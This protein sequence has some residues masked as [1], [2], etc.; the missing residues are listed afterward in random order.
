MSQLLKLLDIKYPIIQAG[1]AGGITTPGLVAATAEAGGLGTIG[2]G[3][4]D[5]AALRN[6]II[7]TRDLTDRPFAVNLFA[8][9]LNASS[10]NVQEMQKF[11]NKYRKEL[12]LQLGSYT[13]K[14]Y[15]YLEEKVSVILEEKISIVSTAFGVL[16]AKIIGQ[17]KSGKVVL[18]GM[19]TSL[20]EA[21]QLEEAG[22]DVIVAQGSEAGGHRGTFD[23]KKYPDGCNIGLHV[24]VEELL[25]NTRLPI[26]A[27]GGIYSKKQAD[28]LM[29][30]GASGVQIGTRF[31]LAREAGTN[32]AYREALLRARGEDTKL[33]KVFSGRPARAIRNRFIDEVDASRLETLPFPVQNQMTK[34]IR[35]A[36]KEKVNADFL[37]LW[38]GQGVGS[39]NKEETAEEIVRSFAEG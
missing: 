20:D 30:M 7:E 27:A 38:A 5:A 8:A 9:D 37:S 17:L 12:G 35:A 31:L 14:A 24:L 3:Y 15:D 21:L 36:G 16:P 18:I 2:A 34:D 6:D 33:T 10:S 1:M 29:A 39:L 22:Y 19:A 25:E 32:Q 23:V 28:A 13:V 4:M 11:L 26:I